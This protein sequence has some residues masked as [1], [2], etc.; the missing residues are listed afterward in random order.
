MGIVRMMES[1]TYTSRR[2]AGMLMTIRIGGAPTTATN[3][4]SHHMLRISPPFERRSS[5]ELEV[6]RG[7]TQSV[8]RRSDVRDSLARER[9]D[10]QTPH[11]SFPEKKVKSN[12]S[13]TRAWSDADEGY[14]S[15]GWF[16]VPVTAD[17]SLAPT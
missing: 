8:F 13:R 11:V 10:R 9:A 4:H 17:S 6:V 2:N 12:G 16:F 14:E 1:L 15:F 7:R 3:I 5:D